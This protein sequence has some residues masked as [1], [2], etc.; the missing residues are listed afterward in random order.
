MSKKINIDVCR[1]IV[2]FLIVA[3]H[4]SPFIK[5]SPEFD[6]FFTRILGRIAV[7]LFLMI[8]GY[9]ILDKSLN[10]ISILKNYTKKIVKTYL[11]C[12]T[13]YLPINAYMSKFKSID[14]IQIIKNILINGTLYHL[15][16]FPA[17][18]LGIWITYFLIRKIG[19]KWSLW[20][21]CILYIIGLLGDSYYG[22]T[23]MNVNLANIYNFILNTFEYTRNGLFYTPIFLYMGYLI[24]TNKIENK[25]SLIY[26]LILFICMTM[27]GIIL[28]YFNLQKH[29]SMYIFL[30]PLMYFLF[31]Y[32]INNSKTSN[33]V[34]RSI[35]TYIYIFHPLFLVVIRFVSEIVG[36]DN[37]FV[38]NNL[39]LYL[40]VCTITI[41][42]YYL[43]EKV[44][45]VAKYEKH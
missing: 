42:S 25:C 23:T 34:L 35:A 10:N 18:I 7:P 8:T 6:F 45:G 5:I 38:E 13:L 20:I 4:I 30:V 3:I 28:H 16:Y 15:W 19:R 33:K 39:I 29:D 40:T 43:L 21:C 44:K 24:K 14:I 26:S 36:I 11:L 31:S 17:L 9:Y 27:E 22:L 37:I 12:I 1:F 41:V 32:L 2:S